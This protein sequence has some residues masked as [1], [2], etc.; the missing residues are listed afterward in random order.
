M[1]FVNELVTCMSNHLLLISI[2]NSIIL[3]NLYY[4]TQWTSL[5]H[6]GFTSSTEPLLSLQSCNNHTSML[7]N[8]NH[9]SYL[10][11]HLYLCVIVVAWLHERTRHS[12]QSVNVFQRAHLRAIAS[13]REYTDDTRAAD[14]ISICKPYYKRLNC[15]LTSSCCYHVLGG[16]WYY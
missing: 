14:T 16:V 11:I 10:S 13:P 12:L 7:A 3:A 1:L 15:I 5:P 4:N 8:S 6:S 2:F 9:I